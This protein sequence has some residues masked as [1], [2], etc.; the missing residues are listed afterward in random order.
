MDPVTAF[1][2]A[3]NV[4]TVIDL[5]LKIVSTYRNGGAKGSQQLREYASGLQALS[6]KLSLNNQSPGPSFSQSP[7]EKS[8]QDCA[9]KAVDIS[10]SLQ[11]ELKPVNNKFKKVYKSIQAS[12]SHKIEDLERELRNIQSDIDTR[13]LELK[14]EEEGLSNR[15]NKLLESLIY[16]SPF[17]RE[18]DIQTQ[19]EGTFEWILDEKRTSFPDWL[20][21]GD[22]I[23]WIRG[24]P[25]S[26][27]STLVKFISQDDGVLNT[28]HSW[29]GPKEFLMIKFYFFLADSTGMQKSLKGFLC[30]LLYQLL[31]ANWVLDESYLADHQQRE[32][33]KLDNWD[34]VDLKR[35]LQNAVN[36]TT[37][38]TR[39]FVLVDGLDEC[40]DG[41]LKAAIDTIKQFSSNPDIKFCVSSRPEQR[42]INQLK[43]ATLLKVEEHT[44]NDIEKFV[45]SELGDNNVKDKE[46]KSLTERLVWNSEGVFLWAI[47]VSKDVR[48]GIENGDSPQQ[49]LERVK[50]LPGDITRLFEDMLKRVSPD[51]EIYYSEAATY[52][53]LLLDFEYA[54]SGY[55]AP[56]S[57]SGNRDPILGQIVPFYEHFQGRRSSKTTFDEETRLLEKIK[58]R[59]NTK[60]R[61]HINYFVVSICN[62]FTE[63]PETSFKKPESVY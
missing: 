29:A 1:G 11:K 63:P 50:R 52:F 14:K 42:I 57:H 22:G 20:R 33:K 43:T 35:L 47:L 8:L 44:W 51:P 28:L 7:T 36:E 60:I 39:I 40:K 31:K 16:G 18:N 23:F 21:G 26:G 61:N 56:L 32:K 13:L 62:L 38:T 54:N 19:H 37:K 9:A 10:N 45:R 55:D 5:G 34:L 49:L 46:W 30:Y 15:K 48:R 58:Q 41:D 6:A 2:L 12:F 25:G 17:T 53:K 4:F 59:I 3:V 27:R 24:K